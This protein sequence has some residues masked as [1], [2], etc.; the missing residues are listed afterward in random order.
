MTVAV[1]PGFARPM[2]EPRLPGWID[3]RWWLSV[4]DLHRLAPEAEIGWFDL[5][6]KPP[7]L[8]AVEL[9]RGLKWLNSVYAGLDFLPLGEMRE[10][11]VQL[12]NG[13]GLTAIQVAEFAVL[14]M[15][16]IAKN[17]PAVVRAQDARQWLNAAPGIRDLAG[18][19][20]LILGLGAIGTRIAAALAGFG[21]EV[22]A[23][24]RHK[25]E[26]ALTPD[27]WRGRLGEFDW[28]VLTVPGT[29]ETEGMIGAAELAGMK[30]EAVLV[31]F[32]RANV[33]DQAALVD[34]LR[35]K[36]I[37]AAMLDVTDPEPLPSDHP[38]WHL[39]NAHITMH[40]SGI[41]TPQSMLRGVERFVENC[42]RYRAGEPLEPWFDAVLGY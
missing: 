13:T 24:R 42:E 38:L 30:R 35:G 10:R 37:C 36:R 11:G 12:T 15:L 40:L 21:V 29:P 4:E 19:K 23:V 18:S 39:D 9:A 14:G 32:A 20:A 5:H 6:E 1:L 33:V 34:A 26:G 16:A 41:P 2:L 7:L 25:A 28:I 31:N 27:E 17:Y 8:Q 22:T 3:A